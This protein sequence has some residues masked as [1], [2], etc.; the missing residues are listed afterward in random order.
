MNADCT[1]SVLSFGQ[2]SRLLG[3]TTH[4]ESKETLHKSKLGTLLG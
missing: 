4:R 1:S 3:E 2:T